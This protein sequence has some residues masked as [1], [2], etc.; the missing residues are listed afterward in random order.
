MKQDQHCGDLFSGQFS[1][2]LHIRPLRGNP[3]GISTCHPVG[4][5]AGSSTFLVN[6]FLMFPGEGLEHPCVKE[7]PLEELRKGVSHISADLQH[8][9]LMMDHFI[10]VKAMEVRLRGPSRT[11]YWKLERNCPWKNQKFLERKTK[12]MVRKGENQHMTKRKNSLHQRKNDCLLKNKDPRKTPFILVRSNN[13]YYC[14][15][16]LHLSFSS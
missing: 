4:W 16:R 2:L 14:S 8:T 10:Q 1:N 15:H 3:T 5:R 12:T 7:V 13:F 6:D 9:Q 11:F